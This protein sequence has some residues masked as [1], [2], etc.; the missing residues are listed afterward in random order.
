MTAVMP[1]NK[2]SRFVRNSQM[3][4]DI[5]CRST[6]YIPWPSTLYCVTRGEFSN[7]K[8]TGME[9]IRVTFLWTLFVVHP[10]N[11]R[12]LVFLIMYVAKQFNGT[13]RTYLVP[14]DALP[15]PQVMARCDIFFN[16]ISNIT[17]TTIPH[18]MSRITGV[19]ECNN[20]LKAPKIS[21]M[22]LFCAPVLS[23]SYDVWGG[24]HATKPLKTKDNLHHI[25][26]L[27]YRDAC[28]SVLCSTGK[29]TFIIADRSQPNRQR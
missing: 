21:Q 28:E 17:N 12:V 29:E 16:L 22:L 5:M 19:D 7:T 18:S 8:Q 3:L 2:I 6:V 1:I 13:L 10:Y 24:R 9:Y 4:G 20:L 25:H 11:I 23:G 27:P 26:F 15:W 14:P